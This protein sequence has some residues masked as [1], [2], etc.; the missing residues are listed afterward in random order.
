MRADHAYAAIRLDLL[1]VVVSMLL[2]LSPEF[3]IALSV[4]ERVSP[5]A[6][7]PFGFGWV[8]EH[9]GPH[10]LLGQLSLA[11]IYGG[12]L[13]GLLGWRARSGLALAALGQLYLIGWLQMRG[14]AVHCHHLL[15][16]TVA[17]AAS[18]CSDVL[19]IGH[20]PT[21]YAG[22]RYRDGLMAV[23]AI[24]AMIFFFPGWFKLTLGGASW[25]S[26]ET[27]YHTTL[28]KAAQYWD[29]PITLSFESARAYAPLSWG[30]ILFELSAPLLLLW[31]KR[32][33][34]FCVLAIGFHIGTALMLNIHFT[35][36]WPCYVALLP[37][38]RWL[39]LTQT[40]EA[41]RVVLRDERSHRMRFALAPLLVG[42]LYAGA[43]MNLSGWPFACYPTFHQEISHKMPLMSVVVRDQEGRARRI[44]H[45]RY[46][47]PNNR[48]WGEN[49]RLAGFY[50]PVDER[51]LRA[52]ARSKIKPLLKPTDDSVTLYRSSI[53]LLNHD[54][55]DRKRLFSI[56]TRDLK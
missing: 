15:W 3:R 30:A 33:G 42:V 20:R 45:Q 8:V 17:L 27:L 41:Q 12:A 16:L 26:G 29:Q 14:A 7:A 31:W 49:W 11:L 34:V 44:H 23:W 48:A 52:F 54:I 40:S 43:T 18:P 1:R 46:L 6:P 32:T 53:N 5:I 55:K 9:I 4:I 56:A 19:R 22:R 10:L 51:A 2:L 36:L 37:W 38:E 35:N 21:L 13:L 50:S 25:L 24:F 47:R 39:A 28:W